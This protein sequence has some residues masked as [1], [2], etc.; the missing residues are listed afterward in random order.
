[1]APLY[2][3]SDGR[4][5]G[6]LLRREKGEADRTLG[7]EAKKVYPKLGGEWIAGRRAW[8]FPSGAEIEIN[9]CEHATDVDNYSTE[10]PIDISASHTY[11]AGVYTLHVYVSNRLYP[12]PDTVHVT[13]QITVTPVITEPV[14]SI[15]GPILPKDSGFPNRDTWLLDTATD[16]FVIESSLKSLLL[17]AR[18]ERLHFP[19]FGT[20]LRN[21]VFTVIGDDLGGG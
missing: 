4:F 14:Y 13:R 21:L 2:W 18:G 5:R 20:N 6:L 16:N 17:T 12:V 1:M 15:I 7:E 10:L 11:D 8:R 9:G 19:E 3:I